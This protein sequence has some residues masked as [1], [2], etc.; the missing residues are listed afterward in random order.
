[1]SANG[2]YRKYLTP[3]FGALLLFSPDSWKSSAFANEPTPF[4]KGPEVSTVGAGPYLGP[5]P[6]E[7]SKLAQV[8]A[9][10]VDSPSLDKEPDATTITTVGGNTLTAEELAK[11]AAF[12]AVPATLPVPFMPKLDLMDVP[13]EGIPELTA[14]EL[15]K[16]A[17]ELS[18]PQTAPRLI[19]PVAPAAPIA[20]QSIAPVAPAPTGAPQSTPR[21]GK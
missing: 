21:S 6:E 18:A 4:T 20:P 12:P 15:Q 1:M 8:E 2:R 9:V 3:M 7:L 10:A 19:S 17:R 14:E 5:L 16:R 13:T 11:L